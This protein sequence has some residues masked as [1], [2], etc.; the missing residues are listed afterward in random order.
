MA[1]RGGPMVTG[2]DGADFEHR[3]R[4]AAHYQIRLN[5]AFLLEFI[6]FPNDDGSVKAC[7][8]KLGRSCQATASQ[9]S[10]CYRLPTQS[11]RINR[12]RKN[13]ASMKDIFASVLADSDS[14]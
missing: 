9:A 7:N 6:A 11:I 14:M 10:D 2:T 4:V 3:Q 12:S 1:S 8:V 13:R 5:F